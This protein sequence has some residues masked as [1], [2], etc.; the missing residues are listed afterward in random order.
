M[1]L[2]DWDRP[3]QRTNY[4]SAPLLV[5]GPIA[6]WEGKFSGHVSAEQI[7]DRIA[8]TCR[9]IGANQVVSDQR[10]EL[11]LES[12]FRARGVRFQSIAW[13]ADN[14]A[15]AVERLRRLLVERRIIL[16]ADETLKRELYGF[17]E[18]VTPSGTITFGARSS[19]HDDR[20]ALLITS[21]LAEQHGLLRGTPLFAGGNG[22]NDPSR[23]LRQMGG[24]VEGY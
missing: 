20:V 13:T 5:V 7:V 12:L 23:V 11:A 14:K 24:T 21:M 3:I 8:Y 2:D 6:A 10:E 4:N 19:G 9:R 15:F 22:R 17:S 1:L 18:K 16:P